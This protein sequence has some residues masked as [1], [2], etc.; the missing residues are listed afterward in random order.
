MEGDWELKYYTQQ[1]GRGFTHYAGT[2]YQS[3]R[4]FVPFV[5]RRYQRGHGFFGRIWKGITLPLLKYIGKR[6]LESAGNILTAAA[7]QPDNIKDILKYEGKRVA[8]QAIEDGSRRAQKFIQE[9]EGPLVYT[10]CPPPKNNKR[11]TFQSPATSR[12]PSG[13]KPHK[14]PSIEYP[15]AASKP[16][17]SNKRG[18]S[19]VSKSSHSKGKQTKSP[20][21][22]AKIINNSTKNTK[23]VS[24]KTPKDKSKKSKYLT[25]LS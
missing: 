14:R 25:F 23:K 12:C 8:S 2:R 19:V 9:G 13:F 6:G 15:V 17:I 11:L 20:S 4:G 5:G 10:Y 1:A 3:G 24:K 18:S 7:T 22:K 21:N 16:S